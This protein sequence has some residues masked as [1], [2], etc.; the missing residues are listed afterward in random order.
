M[1]NIS[2]VGDDSSETSATKATI[3]TSTA[4]PE[5]SFDMSKQFLDSENPSKHAEKFN[6]AFV[7]QSKEH[8]AAY[9]DDED[10]DEN[11]FDLSEASGANRIQTNDTSISYNFD[12]NS[13]S[14]N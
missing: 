10:L 6:P 8:V 13:D 9:V 7:V 11:D 5:Q 12:S 3:S 1:E 14:D 2:N 4:S